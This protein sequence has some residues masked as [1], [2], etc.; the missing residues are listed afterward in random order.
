[1][2]Q[3]EEEEEEEEEKESKITPRGIFVEAAF[4]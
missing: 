4:P 3:E 2:E 1:M